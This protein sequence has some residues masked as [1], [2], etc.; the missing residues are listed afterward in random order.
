[1]EKHAVARLIGASPGYVGYEEGGRLTEAIRRSGRVTLFAR[2]K[3][4]TNTTARDID[5]RP[6]PIFASHAKLALASFRYNYQNA[7]WR[8]PWSANIGGQKVPSAAAALAGK[9]GPTNGSFPIDYSTRVDT[10]PAYSALDV[11]SGRISSKDLAG[12]DVVVGA[13]SDVLNDNFFIP[14]YGRAFG[15]QVHALGA[16]TLKQ[17]HPVEL[18][19]IPG[20]LLAVAV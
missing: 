1:M 11:L 18:G 13:G 14:G 12:K 4:G 9:D 8:L 10:I 5:G 6:L 19:W 20:L 3:T 7:V 15:V 17:G 16:E 2:S